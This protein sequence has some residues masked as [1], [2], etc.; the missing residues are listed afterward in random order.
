VLPTGQLYGRLTDPAALVVATEAGQVLAD[1]L[2]GQV[3]LPGAAQAAVVHA[4]R[5]LGLLAAAAVR[6]LEVTG[7]PPEPQLVRLAVP[8]GS[9]TVAVRRV[10]GPPARTTCRDVKPKVPISYSPLWLRAD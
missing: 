5:E 6:V 2:R 7:S 1:R 8:D 3:G 4:R 10:T 9:C